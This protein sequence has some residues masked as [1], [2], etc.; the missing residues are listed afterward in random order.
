VRFLQL[1]RNLPKGQNAMNDIKEKV[2]QVHNKSDWPLYLRFN[3]SIF[4]RLGNGHHDCSIFVCN[5]IK[6][7]VIKICGLLYFGRKLPIIFRSLL[8]P[9]PGRY[10]YQFCVK[11]RCHMT[12]Q[13]WNHICNCEWYLQAASATAVGLFNCNTKLP[14]YLLC[15][16]V[17]GKCCFCVCVLAWFQSSASLYMKSSLFWHVTRSMLLLSYI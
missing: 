7:Y 14:R 15:C 9:Y 10:G 2:G 16:G 13:V 12:P 3:P 4:C 17:T 6:S 5:I 8:P 1:L 11:H